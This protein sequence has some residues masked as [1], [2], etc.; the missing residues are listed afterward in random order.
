MIKKI[1]YYAVLMAIAS[2]NVT[3]PTSWQDS[4]Y[5]GQLNAYIQTVLPAKQKDVEDATTELL[6]TI[7]RQNT[8]AAN[9]AAQYRATLNQ[10]NQQ[11]ANLQQQLAACITNN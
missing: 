11:I 7:S 1:I 5:Y 8:A 9:L 2:I 4:C 3:E 10:S 6:D